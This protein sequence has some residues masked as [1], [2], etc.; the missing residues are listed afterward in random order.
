M[1]LPSHERPRNDPIELCSTHPHRTPIHAVG[2]LRGESACRLTKLPGL[3]DGLGHFLLFPRRNEGLT[4]KHLGL[5]DI[6][7]FWIDDE[8]A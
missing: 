5:A 7:C 3:E 2:I 8:G 6:V 4:S 1:F